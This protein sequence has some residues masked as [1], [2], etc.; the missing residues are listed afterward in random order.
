MSDMINGRASCDCAAHGCP[1]L[2]SLTSSTTG[3]SEWLC[4]FHFGKEP[5]QWQSIT[6]QLREV[7]WLVDA[8]RNIRMNY[9]TENWGPVYLGIKQELLR[10][11]REDLTCK[12]LE[13][14]RMWSGRIE[15]AIADHVQVRP[16]QQKP[17]QG[18]EV[19]SGTWSKVQYSL[20]EGSRRPA[21]VD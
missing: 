20:P 11:G 17:L 3:T 2:G 4:W 19:K 16:A 5:V 6:A 10:N 9:G 1:M 7:G 8:L 14:V 15:K 18:V 21:V 13:T 12:E